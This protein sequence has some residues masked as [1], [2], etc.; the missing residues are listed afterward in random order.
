M[1]KPIGHCRIERL[2]ALMN[3][4]CLSSLDGLPV[5]KAQA[6]LCFDILRFD[7]QRLLRPPECTPRPGF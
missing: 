3:F 2:E 1:E 5:G 4:H 7:A 6:D